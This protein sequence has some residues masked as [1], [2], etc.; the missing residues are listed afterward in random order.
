MSK[1]KTT[2]YSN[3]LAESLYENADNFD[4]RVTGEVKGYARTTY[5][6]KGRFKKDNLSVTNDNILSYRISNDPALQGSPANTMFIAKVQI[7]K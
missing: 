4:V 2:N 5:F 6:P 7:L 3:K 1:E